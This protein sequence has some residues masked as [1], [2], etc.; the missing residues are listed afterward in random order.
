MKVRTKG[1]TIDTRNLFNTL[2]RLSYKNRQWTSNVKGRVSLLLYSSLVDYVSFTSF[3]N[4]GGW[5]QDLID[6]MPG[7][8]EQF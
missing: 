8:F 2:E 4:K 6:F 7:K 1:R 5:N 3:M